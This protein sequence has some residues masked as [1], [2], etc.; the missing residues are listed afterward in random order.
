MVIQK[1][2]G[3]IIAALLEKIPFPPLWLYWNRELLGELSYL[4]LKLELLNHPLKV[5]QRSL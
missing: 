4:L 2:N 5:I 1:S 3:E